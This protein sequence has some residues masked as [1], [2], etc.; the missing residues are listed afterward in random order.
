M[1][2]IL[3]T[4]SSV[5]G[6]SALLRSLYALLTISASCNSV[7]CTNLDH[8][9]ISLQHT[10]GTFIRKPQQIQRMTVQPRVCKLPTE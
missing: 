9:F 5:H 6:R 7:Y 2:G 1:K 3:I 10:I 8:L 4:A